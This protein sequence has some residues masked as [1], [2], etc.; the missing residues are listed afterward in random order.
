MVFLLNKPVELNI[1]MLNYHRIALYRSN[2]TVSED[3]PFCSVSHRLLMFEAVYKV[4][5][6]VTLHLFFPLWH[7]VHVINLYDMHPT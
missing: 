6:D 5:I 1:Y 3:N 4:V 7:H 2:I